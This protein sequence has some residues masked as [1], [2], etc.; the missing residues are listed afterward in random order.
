MISFEM[1]MSLSSKIAA[2]EIGLGSAGTTKKLSKSQ[3]VNFAESLSKN[4]VLCL[5]WRVDGETD[6]EGFSETPSPWPAPPL[7]RPAVSN[8]L[9]LLALGAAR[10][11]PTALLL[12][13]NSTSLCQQA[14]SP[15]GTMEQMPRDWMFELWATLKS[16]ALFISNVQARFQIT[17]VLYCCMQ[18]PVG[19]RP[20]SLCFPRTHPFS[21]VYSPCILQRSLDTFCNLK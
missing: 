3:L 20:F 7:P 18:R 4:E 21:G 5:M 10:H 8:F 19:P 12:I 15:Q 6:A 17:A 13:P 14:S 16:F 9:Q 1:L 2:C 11:P